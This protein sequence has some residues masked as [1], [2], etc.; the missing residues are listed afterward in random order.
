MA[1]PRNRTLDRITYVLCRLAAMFVQMVGV[2]SLYAFARAAGKL[3]CIVDRRHYALACE[4]IRLSFPD[5]DESA[6]RATAC[7]SM[8]AIVMLAVEMLLLPR[9]I[10]LERYTRHLRFHRIDRLL[11][12]LI[13]E[14]TGAIMVLGHFGNW[15]VGGYAAATLGF[16]AVAVARPIDNPHVDRYIRGMRERTGLRIVD[17]RGAAE[18]I[19]DTLGDHGIVCFV[20]AQDAERKALFVDFFGRPAS[21]FK[22]VAVVAM[23]YNVPIM[24]TYTKRLNDRFEFEMGISAVISPEQWAHQGDPVRWITETYTAE[25]EKIVRS[26]P[27]QYFGWAHRRWKHRPDGTKATGSGAA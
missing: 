15:E 16:P 27:G 25:L 20:A 2:R 24:V 10:T 21:T 26:D 11:R 8:Q 17:K 23:L 3:L 12:V 6:V 19:Q 9:K 5:W 7:R 22:S 14:Q 4:Q 13:A 1:K 18:A